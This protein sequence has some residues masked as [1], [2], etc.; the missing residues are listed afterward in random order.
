MHIFESGAL[1]SSWR[2]ADAEGAWAISLLVHEG[3]WRLLM[4]ERA[5]ESTNRAHDAVA[6]PLVA[7]AVGE[8]RVERVDTDR[9]ARPS[10]DI[11]EGVRRG[12]LSR[13]VDHGRDG[14]RGAHREVH[15]TGPAAFSDALAA[16]DSR[17]GDDCALA[18][19]S[20]TR[21]VDDFVRE[22]KC[23]LWIVQ[24]NGEVTCY[25][26]TDAPHWW[27]VTIRVCADGGA[28]LQLYGG[29]P[30][31]E[32]DVWAAGEAASDA[33]GLKRVRTYIE[34]P[35]LTP[36]RL[37]PAVPGPGA[38]TTAVLGVA[39]VGHEDAGPLISWDL[40]H[41]RRGRTQAWAGGQVPLRACD[42]LRASG[43]CWR[44]VWAE[45][46]APP[47]LAGP[48]S[49][50]H[51]ERRRHVLHVLT[52]GGARYNARE[53]A[54]RQ[55]ATLEDC[56]ALALHGEAHARE[57]RSP[58][59]DG[60]PGLSDGARRAAPGTTSLGRTVLDAFCARRGA[61]VHVY[62]GSLKSATYGRA[63]T[64]PG[65]SLKLVWAVGTWGVLVDKMGCVEPETPDK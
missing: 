46:D 57:A 50:N 24:R 48:G 3:H 61:L 9:D 16:C 28:A 44:H 54:T 32:E 26:S 56:L 15:F 5:C 2:G 34:V 41:L 7:P 39:A 62:R 53:T 18:R 19:A 8:S 27:S 6:R 30:P 42:E 45:T 59:A 13:W 49:G 21:R 10:C 43:Y 14:P 47:T 11:E 35:E 33:R 60:T 65:R 23:T 40:R 55:T 12:W 64:E 31:D 17:D 58:G 20:G 22:R 51:R 63:L 38:A 37:L 1:A 52:P 29:L 4:R 36:T 25:R